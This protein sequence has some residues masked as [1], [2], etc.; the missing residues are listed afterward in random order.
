MTSPPQS[1]LQIKEVV[2]VEAAA[3][4]SQYEAT[5]SLFKSVAPSARLRHLVAADHEQSPI[6][7]S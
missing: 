5:A 1:P 3:A 6:A 4:I 2:L 7:G